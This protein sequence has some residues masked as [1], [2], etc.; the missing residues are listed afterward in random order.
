[1]DLDKTEKCSVMIA[2]R[3]HKMAKDELQGSKQSPT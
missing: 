1:M 2:N 3:G